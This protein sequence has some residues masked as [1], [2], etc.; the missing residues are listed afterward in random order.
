MF[1]ERCI[2]TMTRSATQLCDLGSGHCTMLQYL[3]RISPVK[4]LSLKMLTLKFTM[5]LAL[6]SGQRVQT[7]HLLNIRN[8]SV[9]KNSVK[10]RLGDLLKQSRPGQHQAELTLKAYAPDRRLC[11]VTVITEYLARTHSIRKHNK[12]LL[13]VVK[14][15]N[16]VTKDTIS[17]W[18]KLTLSAA[19]VDM[20]V[21]T[22][23]STRA[24]STSAA[25]RALIPVCS[26]LQ[27]AG[28]SQASTFARY[29][30][31]PIGQ[32]DAVNIDVLKGL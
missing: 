2:P 32:Q 25:S 30:Q 3:I 13:S 23:H 10:L 18:L 22:P 6:L 28:W 24:A 17:R 20:A 14:P 11:I 8:I 27:T 12:L 7:L 9:S 29:Y 21:F 16:P 31:K 4:S 1:P 15:H 26:I 5:L 19:G